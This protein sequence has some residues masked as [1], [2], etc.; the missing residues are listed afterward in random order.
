MVLKR[1]NGNRDNKKGIEIDMM[2][3]NLNEIVFSDMKL[4]ECVKNWFNQILSNVGDRL[5]TSN[6]FWEFFYVLINELKNIIKDAQNLDSW[7]VL[8]LMPDI[9]I[10]VIELL[11][12]DEK[13]L[14]DFFSEVSYVVK[15]ND[16]NFYKEQEDEKLWFQIDKNVVWAITNLSKLN[17]DLFEIILTCNWEWNNN[18]KLAQKTLIEIGK[19]IE[20]HLLRLI[21]KKELIQKLNYTQHWL[22]TLEALKFDFE[23]INCSNNQLLIA[24]L[25]VQ[26][27][28]EYIF[29]E[30]EKI[31]NIIAMAIKYYFKKMG[32][33]KIE[34]YEISKRDIVLIYP[35]WLNEESRVDKILWINIDNLLR[36]SWVRSNT[37]SKIWNINWTKLSKTLDYINPYFK[38]IDLINLN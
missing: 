30:D 38:S 35:N 11:N 7:H 12:A 26:I 14:K 4:N 18:H 28:K 20:F 2:D 3:A 5:W 1:N 21:T 32:L 13:Q 25:N 19:K 23:K 22:K 6:D 29:E 33:D 31:D 8:D 9:F 15:L 37:L 16:I 17:F 34:I 10:W 27:D 24:R 36:D